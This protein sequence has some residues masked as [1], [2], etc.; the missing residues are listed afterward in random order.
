MFVFLK[1]E[2]GGNRA[3]PLLELDAES[4]M[5][6]LLLLLLLSLSSSF[7]SF[8]TTFFLSS[9]LAATSQ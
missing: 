2:G 9:G 1:G 6:L 8:F 5:L 4:L 3:H 7:S